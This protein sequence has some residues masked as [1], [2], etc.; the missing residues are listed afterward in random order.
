[1][2]FRY[3]KLPL[4]PY[5]PKHP[6]VARPFLPIHLIGL[7]KKTEAPFWA[8]LDSGADRVII[9]ADLAREVGIFHIERGRSEPAMGISGQPVPVFYHE[10][11]IEII[12]GSDPLPLE[13]GF[14]ANIPFPIL[15][16]SFFQ[17]F[18]SVIFHEKNEEI[19]LKP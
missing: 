15:G 9:P 7:R 5:D 10:L 19:E 2:K 18:R 6:L 13:V 17:H 14:M 4:G 1:M 8:L 12:G 3:Q 16:R 11:K